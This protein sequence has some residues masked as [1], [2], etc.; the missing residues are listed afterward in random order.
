LKFSRWAVPCSLL[1]LLLA[2]GGCS[3]SPPYNQTPAITAIVPSNI[4]AGSQ[5]FSIFIS[6]TGFIANA[7]GATFGY[8]NG[9][10]R[11][12]NYNI[13][14]GQLQMMISAADVANPGQ[15]QITVIS[16][17]PGGGEA[18]TAATFYVEAPQAG[19]PVISSISPV[20]ASLNAKPPLITITG[21]NFVLGDV[22]TW[23]GQSRASGSAYLSQ[24]QMTIQPVA[25]DMTTAGNASIS[26]SDPGLVNAS[27]SVDFAINGTNAPSPSVGSLSP[28][29]A[30]AGAADLQVV[31][32]GSGFATNSTALWNS[33]PL[34]TSYLSASALIALVPAADLAAAGSAEISVMTPAPGGGTSSTTT[35]T[36]KAQ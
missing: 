11:S 17:P 32:R 16:P 28:S 13:T 25:N 33:T 4:T 2:L 12:T 10:A 8:W 15:V 6:G 14:T 20:S 5:D 24:T 35:F 21:T 19:W 22:V 3:S 26:V 27:P 36:I 30:T 29:S 31:V 9:S 23:N 34:A 1:G 18:V 7:Q